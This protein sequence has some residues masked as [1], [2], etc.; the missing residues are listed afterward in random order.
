MPYSYETQNQIDI[1]YHYPPELLELLC[2]V[3][4]VLF[5]SKPGVIDFFV[6]AGVPNR[7]VSDWKLKLEQDKN[8]VRKH[9]VARSVLCRMNDAGEPALAMRR[10]VLKRVSEFEDFSSCWENDRYKAQGLVAQI[11]K[12]VNI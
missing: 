2:D 6:G 3:V 11:Q 8:S 4:P 1:S 9:E 12:L 5:R 7:L 10:E